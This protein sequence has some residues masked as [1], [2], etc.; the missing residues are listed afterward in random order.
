MDKKPHCW[1]DYRAY[2]EELYGWG[3]HE[4]HE[5]FEPGKSGTC[6]LETGHLGPHEFIPD[7]DII[8]D[9]K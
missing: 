6:M 2:V 7:E 3:S 4:W 8:I 1:K 9:F 5:T